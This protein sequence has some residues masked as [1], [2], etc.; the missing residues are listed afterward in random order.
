MDLPPSPTGIRLEEVRRS[1][2]KI[3]DSSASSAASTLPTPP[4]R[5]ASEGFI[6]PR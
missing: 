3:P 4:A 1:Y 6:P 2:R 5:I